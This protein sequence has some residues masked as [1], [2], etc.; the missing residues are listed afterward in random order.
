MCVLQDQ[1]WRSDWSLQD[2][3]DEADAQRE[4]RGY[5]VSPTHRVCFVDGVRVFGT[6]EPVRIGESTVVF[7]D[8]HSVATFRI[9]R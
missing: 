1:P 2:Y 9:V 8:A 5:R 3:I 4:S 6:A 7:G